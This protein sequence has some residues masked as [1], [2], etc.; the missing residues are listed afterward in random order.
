MALVT[1]GASG[2]GAE[3]ARV[4]ARE[5]AKVAITDIND[6]AGQGVAAEIGEA[7]AIYV[8]LDTRSEAASSFAAAPS[9]RSR[10]SA[11]AETP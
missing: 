9:L 3:T 2:I 8:S 6:A 7:A 5:G 11:R 10:T 1:G 4:F